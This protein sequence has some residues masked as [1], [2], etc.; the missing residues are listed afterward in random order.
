MPQ[1]LSI[2]FS[3]GQVTASDNDQGTIPLVVPDSPIYNFDAKPRVGANQV[4]PSEGT[5]SFSQTPSEPESLP[6]SRDPRVPTG[7]TFRPRLKLAV[8]GRAPRLK[9]RQLWEGTV[10]EVREG[11]FVA[12]LTDKTNPASPDEQASF[13]FD[14]TE[15]SPDDLRLINPGATFYWVIGNERTVAGQVKNVSMLQFRRVPAWTQ[16][17]L[18]R[19]AD[20]AR[21]LRESFQEKA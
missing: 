18:D 2:T 1:E 8:P 21:R 19:A 16:H 5:F 20:S 7:A 11:G 3:L 4:S 6:E 10:V 12:V 9:T 13:D 17:R 15:I 14:N